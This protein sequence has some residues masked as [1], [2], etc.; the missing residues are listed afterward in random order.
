MQCVCALCFCLPES[1][2]HHLTQCNYTEAV[3]NSIAN[4]FRLPSF[5]VLSGAGGPKQWVR[6]LLAAGPKKEKKRKLGVL[7]TF[8]WLIWKERNSRIFEDKE[9]SLV[10][11]SQLIQE[12]IT[13]HNSVFNHP[14]DHAD[15][16]R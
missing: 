1:T 4:K 13:L 15:F 6:S 9:R 2:D 7:F 16:S 10:S 12:E 14:Q 3:W 5:I 11:L 8:W